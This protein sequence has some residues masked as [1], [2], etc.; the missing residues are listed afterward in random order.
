MTLLAIGAIVV[1]VL[2]Y[3]F[4]TMPQ[5]DVASDPQAAYQSSESVDLE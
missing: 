3:L 4:S 5:E 1:I 2:L